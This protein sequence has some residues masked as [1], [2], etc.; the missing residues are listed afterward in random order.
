MNILEKIPVA[1]QLKKD[2][3]ELL[4]LRMKAFSVFYDEDCPEKSS[5]IERKTCWQELLA[6]KN[7]AAFGDSDFTLENIDSLFSRLEQ[8]EI[9]IEEFRKELKPAKDHVNLFTNRLQATCTKRLKEVSASGDEIA[10]AI[11]Q[12]LTD[13]LSQA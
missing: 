13:K 10:E 3:E 2:Y 5:I 6:W 11:K 8:E 4:P 7:G 9:S 12:E 1:K